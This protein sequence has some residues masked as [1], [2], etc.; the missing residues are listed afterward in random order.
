MGTI[1]STWISVLPVTN[2]IKEVRRVIH[3]MNWQLLNFPTNYENYKIYNRKEPQSELEILIHSMIGT[4]F[5]KYWSC[6][7]KEN[8]WVNERNLNTIL[9]ETNKC[10]TI[11]YVK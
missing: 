9:S 10:M 8:L 4:E 3:L 2:K 7:L 1:V 6:R 5:L 11:L